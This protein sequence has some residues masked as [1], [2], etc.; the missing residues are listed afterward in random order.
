MM[1]RMI[2]RLSQTIFNKQYVTP[3]TLFKKREYSSLSLNEQW[4]KAVQDGWR[5]D[6]LYGKF[7]K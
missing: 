4:E 1:G 7:Y 3:S 6:P 2:L 5:F